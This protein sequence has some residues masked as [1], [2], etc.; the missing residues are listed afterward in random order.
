MTMNNIKPHDTQQPVQANDLVLLRS[1]VDALA[2]ANIAS[3]ICLGISVACLSGCTGFG[4]DSFSGDALS[5]RQILP[6]E[7]PSVMQ[8]EPE[9]D[10]VLD[11]DHKTIDQLAQMVGATTKNPADVLADAAA[12]SS[13]Q[14]VRTPA[15]SF[16][17]EVPPEPDFDNDFPAADLAAP[18]IHKDA[19]FIDASAS[20]STS[21]TEAG[22]VLVATT[23]PIGAGIVI[24]PNSLTTEPELIPQP[25]KPITS[26]LTQP[27]IEPQPE[28]EPMSAEDISVA[29]GLPPLSAADMHELT[30]SVVTAPSLA[31]HQ[32]VDLSKLELEST[33]AAKPTPPAPQ[34]QEKVM[35]PAEHLS[36]T[37]RL[38][39]ETVAETSVSGEHH[40]AEPGVRLLQILRQKMEQVSSSN[41]RLSNQEH[42]YWQQQLEAVSVMFE[43]ESSDTP[44]GNGE[45]QRQTATRAIEHLESAAQHLRSMAGLKVYGGQLCSQI[46][47]FGKFEELES[48]RFQPGDRALIY[49][50]VENHSSQMVMSDSSSTSAN[51]S[52]FQTRLQASYVVHD[53]AGKIVHEETYPAIEDMARRHRRDFYLHLPV[54]ILELS[55]GEYQI[56]V[57]IEDLANANT[58]T[59]PAIDFSVVQPTD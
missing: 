34:P 39:E 17:T 51:S 10:I 42:Q 56:T 5:S 12:R 59:L 57:S 32:S 22:V 20:D 49:V 21:L 28:P 52:T 13:S 18:M 2:W 31:S 43:S 29:V 30:K 4:T 47:G 19:E 38:I 50:E 27:K 54:T 37:I 35:T 16:T 36:E 25:L 55:P 11:D 58:A 3:F 6:P 14:E 46:L 7:T 23:E 48:N 9:H 41:W 24:E 8:A 44:N 45:P 1:R 33:L 40:G 15:F 26:S 53:S